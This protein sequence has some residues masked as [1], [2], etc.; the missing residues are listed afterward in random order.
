MISIGVYHSRTVAFLLLPESTIKHSFFW[1]S[2][3][4]SVYLLTDH[5]SYF[6]PRATRP[7]SNQRDTNQFC[8]Y[9]KSIQFCLNKGQRFSSRKYHIKT[10]WKFCRFLLREHGVDV[11]QTWPK[12]YLC[13]VC[14][15]K[16]KYLFTRR[17]DKFT[18]EKEVEIKLNN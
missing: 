17:N 10:S 12:A 9:V 4:L 15:H 18:L 5:I 2:E 16:R 3:R 13:N 6:F 1:M 11:N 14:W 7:V 8:T